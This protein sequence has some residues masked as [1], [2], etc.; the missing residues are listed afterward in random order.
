MSDWRDVI[1]KGVSSYEMAEMS[2][3]MI[4]A[5]KIMKGMAATT[6]DIGMLCRRFGIEYSEEDNSFDRAV[7]IFHNIYPETTAISII[8]VKSGKKSDSIYDDLL[9]DP[10]LAVVFYRDIETKNMV[11]LMKGKNLMSTTLGRTMIKPGAK[12]VAVKDDIELWEQ[13]PVTLIKSF[14]KK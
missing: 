12:F 5:R 1:K 7:K 6:K 14:S 3:S 4:A 9:N 11:A 2:N 8:D 13:E 10:R